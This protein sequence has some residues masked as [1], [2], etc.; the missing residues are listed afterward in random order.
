M[1]SRFLF[2][3]GLGRKDAEIARLFFRCG[4]L[5]ADQI[6]YYLRNEG[7]E[8]ATRTVKNTL[9]ELERQGFLVSNRFRLW[10]DS[11]LVS[12]RPYALAAS[13]EKVKKC[14]PDASKLM[15]EKQ[16]KYEKYLQDPEQK[17]IYAKRYYHEA[18]ISDFLAILCAQQVLKVNDWSYPVY[19]FP[20]KVGSKSEKQKLVPDV[21]VETCLNMKPYPR[22]GFFLEIDWSRKG[23]DEI[24]QR[25]EK[26]ITYAVSRRWKKEFPSIP[27]LLILIPEKRFHQ[28]DVYRRSLAVALGK[29][30]IRVDKKDWRKKIAVGVSEQERFIIGSDTIPSNQSEKVWIDLI[31]GNQHK[32]VGLLG[33]IP[34][35]YLES[36]MRRVEKSR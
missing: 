11:N 27:T 32:R 12:I 14:F 19:E 5:N 24:V 33:L 2:E 36:M 15:W 17:I 31:D 10:S 20:G 7:I 35:D 8:L 29:A 18:R 28:L 22:H 21:L 16:R 23:K 30:K 6:T 9:Y 3:S 26:Y 4:I 34:D 1:T 25:F 13:S